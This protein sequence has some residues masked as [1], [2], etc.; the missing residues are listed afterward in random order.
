MY[1]SLSILTFALVCFGCSTSKDQVTLSSDKLIQTSELDNSQYLAHKKTNI[2]FILID[3]LSHYGVTAYGA[4][5]LHSYDNEFTNKQLVWLQEIAR[6]KKVVLDVFASPYSLLQLKTITNIDA[7]V[8]SYQNSKIAQDFSAQLLFGAIEGKGK[9]PVSINPYF[10]EGSFYSLAL[11]HPHQ[12]S[13]N[14]YHYQY[15]R[16]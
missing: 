10:S 14:A 6:E 12:K 9:L 15:Q 11:N 7:I 3:D 1:K 5:R 4:N 2:V 16:L 8:V 13:K